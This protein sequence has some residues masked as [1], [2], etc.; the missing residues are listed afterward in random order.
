MPISSAFRRLAHD[1]V[2]GEFGLPAF[3]RGLLKIGRHLGRLRQRGGV[4]FGQAVIGHESLGHFAWQF[5]HLRAGLLY[6]F[7]RNA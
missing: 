2:A 1:P 4:I 3:L 6:P 7:R 5:G